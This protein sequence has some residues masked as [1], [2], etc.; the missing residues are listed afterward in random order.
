MGASFAKAV[1]PRLPKRPE[2]AREPEW[3]LGW[4]FPMKTE[5]PVADASPPPPLCLH[6]DVT[7][8]EDHP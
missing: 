8:H 3:G 4:V 6:D 2:P 5:Q 1:M 7:H